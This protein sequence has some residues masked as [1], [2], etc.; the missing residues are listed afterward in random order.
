M[1]LGLAICP[2]DMIFMYFLLQQ[3]EMWKQILGLTF[4]D[5][6]FGMK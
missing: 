5:W 2:A 4:L 6:V 1:Q 3:E